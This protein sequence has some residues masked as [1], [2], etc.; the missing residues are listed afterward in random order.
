MN[1]NL[2]TYYNV[3]NYLVCCLAIYSNWKHEWWNN[4]RRYHGRV[5]QIKASFIEQVD[6]FSGI[7]SLFIQS[8]GA[9]HSPSSNSAKS[10]CALTDRWAR[11][12]PTNRWQICDITCG[13][14]SVH[15]FLGL[16]CL[17]WITPADFELTIHFKF[18]LYSWRMTVG[19]W[20]WC[21]FQLV[22][23]VM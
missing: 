7:L 11:P 8:S 3:V 13:L 1:M 23:T 18:Q 21:S 17:F 12:G 6:I 9:I 4:F 16:N 22:C 19:I 2:N 5:L 15:H 20:L 10:N 14:M